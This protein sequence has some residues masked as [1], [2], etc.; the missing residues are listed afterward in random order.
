MVAHLVGLSLSK[1]QVE[2]HTCMPF[3]EKFVLWQL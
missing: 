3:M 2:K 1:S